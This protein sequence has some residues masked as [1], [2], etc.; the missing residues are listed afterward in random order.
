MFIMIG[1]AGPDF[2]PDSQSVGVGAVLAGNRLTFFFLCMSV[3]L[4]WASYAA[5]YYVRP[6][7]LPSECH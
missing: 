6:S 3:P 2:N 1:C 7:L 4:S 5:D